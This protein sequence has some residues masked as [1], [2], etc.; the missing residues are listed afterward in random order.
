[1][2][3]CTET[4]LNLLSMHWF[5]V[6]GLMQL[7]VYMIHCTFACFLVSHDNRAS[8]YAFKTK[9]NEIGYHNLTNGV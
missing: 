5:D 4:W 8:Q 1:M 9:I 3:N 2:R 7:T 6:R